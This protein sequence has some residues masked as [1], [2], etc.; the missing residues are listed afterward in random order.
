MKTL[1][2]KIHYY[3]FDTRTPEGKSAWQ[4]FKAERENGPRPFGPVFHEIGSSRK[5]DGR[6][7]TLETKHLFNNQWNT[8]PIKGVT[9]KGLRVFD[10]FI[11]ADHGSH[12]PNSAPHGIK[13]GHYLEQTPEM[14]NLRSQTVCCGYCGHQEPAE[15]ANAFCSECLDS[16]YLKESDLYLLRMVPVSEKNG[17]RKPLTA[18][19]KGHLLPLYRDAQIHGNTERGK[20]RIKAQRARVESDYKSAIQNA[21]IKHDGFIWLMDRG[22][23]TQNVIYYSH[24]RKFSFGWQSPIDETVLSS[25]LD[26]LPEFPFTYEIKRADGRTLDSGNGESSLATAD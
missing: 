16:E 26:T 13:R 1:Q 21:Q 6:T 7:V 25:L 8:G 19:E 2:T 22:V 3:E 5:L 14:Q 23:N 24:T 9:E 15:K 12:I 4:A 11:Q 18:A 10:W 20:A 17:T